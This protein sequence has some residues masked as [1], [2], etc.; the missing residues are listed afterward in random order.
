MEG[1]GASSTTQQQQ[2]QDAVA[3]A[4][5]LD[6]LQ[7]HTQFAANQLALLRSV[8]ALEPTPVLTQFSPQQ[9]PALGTHRLWAADVLALLLLASQP[10]IDAAVHLSGVLPFVVALAL[11]LDKC[12]ALHFRVL[13]MLHCCVRSREE[14]LWRGL[15]QEGLGVGISNSGVGGAYGKEACPPLHELLACI[16]EGSRVAEPGCCWGARKDVQLVPSVAA[17]ALTCALNTGG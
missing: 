16:G 7:P 1:A 13:Q 9:Q 5:G 17:A 8:L 11:S 3:Q 4:A 12:N 10:G 14:G 2:Q 6:G 15:F